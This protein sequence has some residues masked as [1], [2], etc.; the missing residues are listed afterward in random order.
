MI[1]QEN[2]KDY[3]ERTV[4]KYG[5]NQFSP[6]QDAGF[7]ACC[8]WLARYLRPTHLADGGAGN[9]VDSGHAAAVCYRQPKMMAAYIF[10]RKG[11]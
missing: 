11:N 1:C 6:M 9:R 7:A 5:N 3:R 4:N 2:N 10:L 8:N